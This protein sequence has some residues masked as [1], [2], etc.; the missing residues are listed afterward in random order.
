MQPEAVFLGLRVRDAVLWGG[1]A[2]LGPTHA[3]LCWGGCSSVCKIPG[4]FKGF[5]CPEGW[6]EGQ[7]PPH[8]HPAPSPSAEPGWSHSLQLV[9]KGAAIPTLM[10]NSKPSLNLH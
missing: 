1:W 6:G 8:H 10:G 9:R 3:C 5:V 2:G 4:W 7:G